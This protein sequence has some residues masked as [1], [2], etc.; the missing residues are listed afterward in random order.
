LQ[1][2]AG[3][4]I[5]ADVLLVRPL[6]SGGM[7]AVWVGKHLPTGGEVAV[8]FV[9]DELAREDPTLLDRFK[10]EASVLTRFASPH[11]VRMYDHGKLGD[12]TP[13]IVM[14]LLRGETLVER[15]ERVHT[16]MSLVDVGRLLEQMAAA[17]Q[18]VHEQGIVHRDLKGENIYLVGDPDQL[19]VKILDFGC[20]KTP[21]MPGHPKLTAPGMLVGSPEYMSPEQIV[22]AMSVDRHADLWAMAVAAYVS[23]TVSFPFKGAKL[24]EMFGAIRG[25]KFTPPSQLRPGVPAAVDAWFARAFTVDRTQRF[26][27]AT[28]MSEAW[29]RALGRGADAEKDSFKR[30]LLISVVVS[31]VLLTLATIVALTQCG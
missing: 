28:G 15:L 25:G 8:K 17:L 27:S 3:A 23:T 10:R 31:V 1:L 24:A 5:G 21:E 14:E 29:W 20:S 4:Q 12:G 18:A 30:V 9:H 6:D 11:V 2:A 13:Y 22:S 16:P 7:G 19:C 26:S